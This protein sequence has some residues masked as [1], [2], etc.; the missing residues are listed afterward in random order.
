MNGNIGIWIV[1]IAVV[2]ATM[3]WTG[4]F[5]ARSAARRGYSQRFWFVVG[6]LLFLLFPIPQ[7]VVEMLPRK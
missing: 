7:F 2:L 6:A 1:V 3:I 5:T 4:R